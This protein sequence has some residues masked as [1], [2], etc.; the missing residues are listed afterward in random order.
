MT[1]LAKQSLL[2]SEFVKITDKGDIR[3]IIKDTFNADLDI[4]GGWG[5]DEKSAVIVHSLHVD[6]EQ[7]F[8]MFA[9]IKATIELSILKQE[10]ERYSGINPSIKNIETLGD[11]TKVDFEISAIK[12]QTYNELIKEYKD[13][14]GKRDFDLEKHFE[15]RKSA[16]LHANMTC[17]FL[18]DIA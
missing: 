15:K 8:G 13:G 3:K 2:M 9:T 6:K 16:T 14:Y 17:W 18:M 7:F 11:F 4:S 10:D 5:Y 1:L 12:K